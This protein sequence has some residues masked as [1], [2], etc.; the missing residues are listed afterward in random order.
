MPSD[1]A[2][3]R[4]AFFDPTKSSTWQE[5]EQNELGLNSALGYE[6]VGQYGMLKAG[7]EDRHDEGDGNE[8]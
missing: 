3:A 4:G 2:E 8:D 7:S 6:G 1:C 5:G